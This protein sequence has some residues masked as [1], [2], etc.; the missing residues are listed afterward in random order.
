MILLTGCWWVTAPPIV[1]PNLRYSQ[2]SPPAGRN[3]PLLGHRGGRLTLAVVKRLSSLVVIA[4][5]AAAAVALLRSNEDP[6]PAEE[7]TPV[8]P[9]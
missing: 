7:W 5:A 8:Q 1:V 6:D 2:T 9:T 4:A 3:D